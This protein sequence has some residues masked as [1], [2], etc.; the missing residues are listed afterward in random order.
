LGL[1][2]SAAGEFG[3][4][5]RAELSASLTA[6]LG[7]EEHKIAQWLQARALDHLAATLL[8]TDHSSLG[9]DGE[10][11]G[12]GALGQPCRFDQLT[13]REAIWLMPDEQ[14]ESLQSRRVRERC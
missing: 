1:L 4:E 13:G 9:K 2:R 10:V 12:E 3:N 6:V 5:R 7:K 14:P 11:S 8:G